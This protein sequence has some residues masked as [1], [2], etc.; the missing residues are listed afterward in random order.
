MPL[1]LC[2]GLIADPSTFRILLY[3]HARP[4]PAI[5]GRALVP[6]HLT[7]F[8][9]MFSARSKRERRASTTLP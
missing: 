3:D 1:A 4:D 9:I 6:C 5:N 8:A 2:G 7:V